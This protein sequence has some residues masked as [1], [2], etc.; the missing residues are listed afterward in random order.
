M[1][2]RKHCLA[3][4]ALFMSA[5][6]SPTLAHDADAAQHLHKGT[7]ADSHGARNEGSRTREE[8]RS[9]GSNR[10]ELNGDRYGYTPAQLNRESSPMTQ[11]RVY[12]ED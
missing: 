10:R 2:L 5:A 7:P 6:I 1:Q 4:V 12:R 11:Y 8:E 3:L 9:Y